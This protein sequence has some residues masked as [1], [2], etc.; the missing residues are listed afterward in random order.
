M[1]RFFFQIAGFLALASAF[2]ALVIDGTRSIAGGAMSITLLGTVLK[3]WEPEIQ[4]AISLRLHPWLWDPV[5]LQFMRLPL[6]V[7]LGALGL[8]LLLV[9]QRRAP[10]IGYS[11]RP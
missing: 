10:A 7:A 2:A 9:T 4:R 3:N 5:T 1:L 8:L 6:W 11:S